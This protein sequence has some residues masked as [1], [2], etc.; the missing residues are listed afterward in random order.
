MSPVGSDDL[1]ER[2][3]SGQSKS[4]PYT[5]P[6]SAS[7]Q[8]SCRRFGRTG[9]G[10]F[11]RLYLPY[12]KTPRSPKRRVSATH[13][14]PRPMWPERPAAE[15]FG[16][17]WPQFHNDRRVEQRTYYVLNFLCAKFSPILTA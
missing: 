13:T 1:K 8:T 9:D 5:A 15:S 14:A 3:A 2:V 11:C 16:A 7:K 6:S 12:D 4:C 17:S 10:H